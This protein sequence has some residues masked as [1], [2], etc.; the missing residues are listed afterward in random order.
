[1]EISEEDAKIILGMSEVCDNEGIGPDD[2]DLKH[3]IYLAF[4]GLAPDG[5]VKL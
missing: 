3:R 5:E 4:P 2:T 1:M